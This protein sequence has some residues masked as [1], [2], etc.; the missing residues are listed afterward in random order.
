[1]I[2]FWILLA[3]CPSM[4]LLAT[5]SVISEEVTVVPFMWVFPLFAYLLSFI[6]CFSGPRWYVRWIFWLE[7]LFFA[8]SFFS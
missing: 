6:L 7:N 8:A 4:L 5:T 1:M 2:G 3:A